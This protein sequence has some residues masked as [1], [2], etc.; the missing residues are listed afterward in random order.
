MGAT[1]GAT[2]AATGGCQC[3]RVRFRV[4]GRLSHPALCH[5]RMC[6]KAFGNLFAALVTVEAITWTKAEPKRFQSSNHVKR[7]FCPDCGTPLTY[8]AP[9]GLSLAIGA[10]DDP[11]AIVPAR[12]YGIE[13]MLPYVAP[14][15]AG[16]PGERTVEGAKDGSYL[17]AIVSYQHPDHPSDEE[18]TP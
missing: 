9:T 18:T 14:L 4:S 16:Q 7:G 1:A 2:N 13:A 11:A 6:Q 8:E 10:F 17:R 5:C 15:A 3:G 12:H